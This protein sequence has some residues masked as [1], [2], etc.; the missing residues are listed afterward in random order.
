V[1]RG[2]QLALSLGVLAVGCGRDSPKPESG[3]SPAAEP[4]AQTATTPAELKLVEAGAEPRRVL[5][6]T[7]TPSTRT[8]Q[9]R[10]QTRMSRGPTMVM[11]L[12]LSWHGPKT[13]SDP[14]TFAVDE[15]T[16]S[17][18][19][20]E[21]VGAGE[22]TILEGLHAMFAMV[23]GE[24]AFDDEGRLR[25]K[26]TKGPDTQPAVPNLLRGVVVALPTDPIGVGAKW[27]IARPPDDTNATGVT[28]V[29]LTAVDGDVLT[30]AVA[31]ETKFADPG[32][33]PEAM[34]ATESLAGTLQVGLDDVLPRA[35]DLQGRLVSEVPRPGEEPVKFEAEL[36]LQLTAS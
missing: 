22:A 4:A 14:W 2:L 13:A 7:A 36:Q 33:G 29:E 3:S 18:E 6:Y 24:V 8:P 10:W 1:R 31:H 21:G 17:G 35:A 15:A 25:V 5:A 32:A 19:A 16:P 9:L 30:L 34:T 20:Y 27:T 23:R 28:E 12:G 26:Q 11:T